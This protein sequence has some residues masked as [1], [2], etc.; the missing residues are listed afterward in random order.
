MKMDLI[1]GSE[2]SAIINQTPGNYPKKIYYKS[3]I[4]YGRP[5][6]RYVSRPLLQLEKIYF[7]GIFVENIKTIL[8]KKEQHLLHKHRQTLKRVP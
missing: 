6:H 1:E 8:S 4:Q 5:Q 2:T 3:E 7:W